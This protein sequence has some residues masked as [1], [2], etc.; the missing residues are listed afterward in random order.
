MGY[1]N[2]NKGL[3]LCNLAVKLQVLWIFDDAKVCKKCIDFNNLNGEWVFR[4]YRIIGM[5]ETQGFDR[6]IVS[7]KSPFYGGLWGFWGVLCCVFH[8]FLP[9]FI[10]CFP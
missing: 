2:K 6:F 5:D 7:T 10:E 1:L 3:E 8:H 9:H 4:E